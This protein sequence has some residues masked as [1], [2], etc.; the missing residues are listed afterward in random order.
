MWIEIIFSIFSIAS[1][2]FFTLVVIDRVIFENKLKTVAE[3]MTG[4]QIQESSGLKLEILKVSG[5][6]Y[7][8]RIQSRLTIFKCRLIFLNGK[9]VSKQRG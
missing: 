7:Y 8:A 2:L 6:T 5:N 1:L 9:L 3:G 4:A